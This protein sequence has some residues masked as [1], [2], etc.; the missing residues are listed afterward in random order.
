MDVIFGIFY[1]FT[2]NLKAI[3]DVNKTSLLDSQFSN[4]SFLF[5]Y[6]PWVSLDS[7]QVMRSAWVNGHFIP[8]VPSYYVTSEIKVQLCAV[9]SQ[10][11]SQEGLVLTVIIYSACSGISQ[12]SQSSGKTGKMCL[13]FGC[14]NSNGSC[15]VVKKEIWTKIV[16]NMDDS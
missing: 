13:R 5:K 2:K 14:M 9:H 3:S 12:F 6:R 8:E 16:P 7:N 11:H 4:S 10:C 1:V 15:H